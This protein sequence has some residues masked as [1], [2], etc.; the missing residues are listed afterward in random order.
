MRA[1]DDGFARARRALRQVDTE[2]DLARLRVV[3][4]GRD[5]S[6]ADLL[7]SEES[8]AFGVEILR[9]GQRPTLPRRRAAAWALAAAV[10]LLCGAGVGIGTVWPAPGET[11]PGSQLP[12]SPAPQPSRE[13]APENSTTTDPRECTVPAPIPSPTPGRTADTPASGICS[14]SPTPSPPTDRP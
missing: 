13:P 6:D 10:A 4:A 1:T 14:P 2:V 5:R 9:T 8:A 12:A 11:A 7:P 3:T